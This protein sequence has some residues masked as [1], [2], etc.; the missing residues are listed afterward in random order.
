MP[1]TLP[2][3]G[4][5][6]P[7]GCLLVASVLFAA[8]CRVRIKRSPYQVGLQAYYRSLTSGTSESALDEAINKLNKEIEKYPTDTGLLALRAS[9]YRELLRLKVGEAGQSFDPKL[10]EQLIRDLRMLNNLAVQSENTPPWIRP[11]VYILVGDLLLLRAAAF[12]PES[13][14]EI[15]KL[16]QIV[17]TALYRLAAD[18]YIHAGQASSVALQAGEN[19][20]KKKLGLQRELIAAREGYINSLDGM[21]QSELFLG[22]KAR[23]KQHLERARELLV[24][25][26]K[27]PFPPHIKETSSCILT[28]RSLYSIQHQI[29]AIQTRALA[30]IDAGGVDPSHKL[31]PEPYELALKEEIA[32]RIFSIPIRPIRPSDLQDDNRVEV[33]LENVDRATVPVACQETQ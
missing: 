4:Y 8:S 22:L 32:A 29:L 21:A 14:A 1:L 30:A 15:E 9:G 19:D 33:A 5:R 20:V 27:T 6:K 24:D 7:L 26:G 25:S 28:P 16:R 18:F 2:A 17:L 23:A 3:S 31:S 11:H 10:A 13:G 12:K